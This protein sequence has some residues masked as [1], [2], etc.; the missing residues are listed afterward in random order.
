[1]C[2]ANESSKILKNEIIIGRQYQGYSIRCQSLSHYYYRRYLVNG[3]VIGEAEMRKGRWYIAE[4]SE[5]PAGTNW[6]YE[7]DV[8]ER[9]VFAAKS[10]RLIKP[11]TRQ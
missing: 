8:L 5:W 7:T 3:V 1:M 9:L 10:K 6:K 4:G 2:T 11:R